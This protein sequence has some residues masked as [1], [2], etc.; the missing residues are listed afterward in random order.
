MFKK[1]ENQTNLNVKHLA[2][3]C[4]YHDRLNAIGD[5]ILCYAGNKGNRSIIFCESKKEC[6]DIL[7]NSKINLECAVLH[8][9]IP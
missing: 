8:G 9:D 6:N 7:M 3:H 1:G 5:I 2:L 4:T